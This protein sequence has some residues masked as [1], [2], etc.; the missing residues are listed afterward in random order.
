M[1]QLAALLDAIGTA[2]CLP[3][4]RCR[5]RHTL[6]DPPAPGEDFDTVTARHDQA[7]GLCSRCP[8]L[9]RCAEW[10]DNLPPRQRPHGVVAGTVRQ[11][12]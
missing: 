6:F 3:G 12:T 1:S 4:A 2:V 8:A 9:T 10:G 11:P 5:G 7:L